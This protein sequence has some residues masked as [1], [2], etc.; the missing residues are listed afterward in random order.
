MDLSPGRRIAPARVL[1]G[2]ILSIIL[3]FDGVR[4]GFADAELATIA[5][6]GTESD[7]HGTGGGAKLEVKFNE[8]TRFKDVR[9]GG[10]ALD[11]NRL[12]ARGEELEDDLKLLVGL[13]AGVAH[14]A[15]YCNY[16]V[17]NPVDRNLCHFE[18]R[19]L[20]LLVLRGQ[21]EDKCKAEDEGSSHGEG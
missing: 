2:W 16:F 4:S 17:V 10:A 7:V 5:I 14:T 13:H 21:E 15:V 12:H 9:F 1:A 3:L 18:L 19:W 6:F 11:C 20:G 8:I